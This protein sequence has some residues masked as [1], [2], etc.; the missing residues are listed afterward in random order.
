MQRHY[1]QGELKGSALT[2]CPQCKRQSFAQTS[3]GF[4]ECLWCGF[5]RSAKP[6]AKKQDFDNS[7]FVVFM[8]LGILVLL[9]IV[10]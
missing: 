1:D 10:G 7:G 4:Y 9:I 6:I 3:K 5:S 2:K 8:L